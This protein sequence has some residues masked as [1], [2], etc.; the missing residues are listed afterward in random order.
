MAV[1]LVTWDLNREKPNYAEARRVF[2]QR[3]G[4]YENT[5][6]PGLDSVRFISTGS[7]AEQ[8]SEDLR[9]RLDNNDKI[10]VTKLRIGEYFGWLN[11]NVWQWIAARL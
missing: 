5:K 10:I 1:Y 3:L 6:D 11:E 7:S 9:Q 4:R 8:V 2:I